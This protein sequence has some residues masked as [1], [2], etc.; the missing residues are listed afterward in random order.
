MAGFATDYRVKA[1]EMD[2]TG[3]GFATRI[4]SKAVKGIDIHTGD[5]K[6]T[7]NEMVI[8]EEVRI[9]LESLAAEF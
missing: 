3:S 2:T 9:T 1:T 8:L 4:C 5:S 6:K 7:I